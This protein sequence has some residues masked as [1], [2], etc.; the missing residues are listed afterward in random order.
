MVIELPESLP[1]C[2]FPCVDRAAE[3]GMIPPLAHEGARNARHDLNEG[4]ERQ[5]VATMPLGPKPGPFLS[6]MVA[7]VPPASGGAV[8][9]T[10]RASALV[11]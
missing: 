9:L 7:G 3:T 8:G 6:R 5:H 4:G 1:G 10:A 11:V 2:G